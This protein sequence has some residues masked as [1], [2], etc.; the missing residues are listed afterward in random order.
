MNPL[1]PCGHAPSRPRIHPRY[2]Y[3]VRHVVGQRVKIFF[4]VVYR[5][6]RRRAV[7]IDSD[8]VIEAL[9]NGR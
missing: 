2:V 1:A 9:L 5:L 8:A 6:C 3:G 4:Q 7:P